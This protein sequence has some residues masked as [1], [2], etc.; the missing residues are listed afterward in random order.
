MAAE[1]LQAAVGGLVGGQRGRRG[2]ERFLD[3]AEQEVR[4]MAQ[5]R[6][7]GPPAGDRGRAG[8]APSRHELAEGE[9]DPRAARARPGRPCCGGRTASKKR[10]GLRRACAPRGGGLLVQ[11]R[12]PVDVDE[13]GQNSLPSLTNIAPRLA[14]RCKR[15]E[16]LPLAAHAHGEVGERLGRLVRHL[17]LSKPARACSARATPSSRRFSSRYS[18]IGRGRTSAR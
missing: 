9:V 10:S 17:E 3:L 1:V 8:S 7:R 13:A 4:A 11:D 5:V 6:A 15:P 16:G 14:K 12:G 18:S 2:P